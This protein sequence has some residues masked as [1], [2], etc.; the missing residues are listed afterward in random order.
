MLAAL[1]V[2]S[3]G[4]APCLAGL[5]DLPG[6]TNELLV[7]LRKIFSLLAVNVGIRICLRRISFLPCGV[8][9]LI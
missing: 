6:R 1:P 2:G 7:S 4:L 8:V 5:L 9:N 3:G